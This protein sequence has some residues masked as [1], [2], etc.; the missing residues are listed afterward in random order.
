MKHL[1]TRSLLAC[2]F[3]CCSSLLSAQDVAAV[4]SMAEK[5]GDLTTA[6]SLGDTVLIR[7]RID[8]KDSLQ[9]YRQDRNFAYIKYLDSLLRETKDLTVDTFSVKGMKMSKAKREAVREN[10]NAV[11]TPKINIFSLPLVK[12]ILW[13][14]AAVLIGFIVWKI[15]LGENFFKRNKMPRHI[16]ETPKEEEALDDASAYDALIAKAVQEKNYRLAV[17]YSFLQSLKKMSDGGMVQFSADKT[18][19]QYV[20]ELHGK[21]YQDDFAS[22]TLNYEYV[23]YGRFEIGE[24]AYTRLSRNFRSFNQKV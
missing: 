9:A 2:I 14:L 18:N 21:P 12:I 19:Y 23:W 7:Y 15:F 24:E 5:T 10:P 4:D 20:N 17:R 22:L 3:L 13:I 16:S 8:I 11:S 1:L 6:A